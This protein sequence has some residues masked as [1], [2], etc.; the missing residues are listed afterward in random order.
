MVW[1]LQLFVMIHSIWITLGFHCDYGIIIIHF[2]LKDFC[3]LIVNDHS[4]DEGIIRCM[5]IIDHRDSAVR[6]DTV[7]VICFDGLG[8][9]VVLEF[10]GRDW[11]KPALFI[12]VHLK[13]WFSPYQMPIVLEHAEGVSLSCLVGLI[14]SFQLH[15]SDGVHPLQCMTSIVG[16]NGGRPPTLLPWRP[17]CLH[18]SVP[19]WHRGGWQ[20]ARRHVCLLVFLLPMWI[21]WS[22]C[23][24][25]PNIDPLILW[26]K[27]IV[28]WSVYHSFVR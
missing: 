28:A 7:D 15:H 13:G 2:V 26:R 21:S 27:Y 4:L 22:R 1:L 8:L 25:T 24:K 12:H 9:F 5:E 16:V 11:M 14:F 10:V 17:R 19:L 18:N 23:R 20:K 3:I 6:S